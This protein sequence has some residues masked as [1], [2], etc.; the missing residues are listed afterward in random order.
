MISVVIAYKKD[1]I[2]RQ[3]NLNFL[4]KI[5][6]NLQLPIFIAEQ[7]SC[8]IKKEGVIEA[9]RKPLIH[10]IIL[11]SNLPFQKSKLYNLAAEKCDS[12]YI[13]FLDAD[14][15]LDFNS[16]LQNL[17]NHPF[18]KP[19][20]GIY[21]LSKEESEL[22]I[23]KGEEPFLENKKSDKHI[24]KYAILIT[25]DLFKSTT[26]FDERIKGWGWEDLDFA[27]NKLK[28]VN[29]FTPNNSKGYH[30]WHPPSIKNHE[31][32]NYFYF[33]ENGMGRKRISFCTAIKNRRFQ[34][35]K[36]LLKN[37]KDNEHSISSTEFVILDC[38]SQDR[39]SEWIL[40]EFKEYLDIGYLKLFKIFDFNYWH[41]S[42]AKNT[43]HYLAEGSILVNL[44][45]DNFTGFN[46]GEHLSVL[47]EDNEYIKCCH[48]WCRKEWFSGNYGRISFERN[49]FEEL[50]G[51]DESFNGMGYQDTD[52]LNRA[53]RM[54][55]G[56]IKNLSSITYNQSIKNDKNF[57]IKNLKP[58]EKEKGFFEIN[59]E[60]E[61]KSIK[62]INNNKLVANK[63][64]FGIRKQIMYY[65]IY[66]KRFH[67]VCA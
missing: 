56:C 11:F 36:T 59:S 67:P 22:F 38:G 66:K 24:G 29:H 42:I 7:K 9:Y 31:R 3:R 40:S 49:F 47:Y 65:D 44:D 15:V 39:V 26:G 4:I 21:S 16:L 34:I 37:L 60:N 19:F 58:S 10:W 51:Y 48:Q 46:G 30:L 35:E 43:A 45:C 27:I 54:T 14:V 8:D 55:P 64:L 12:D 13:L 5:L 61:K 62:N 2:E 63:G 57:S 33:K 32:K 53:E 20:S 25:N 41:A 23:E 6:K 50:G 1:S 17:S 18:I 52:I 28:D